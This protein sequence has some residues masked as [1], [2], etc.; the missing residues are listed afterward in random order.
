[1]YV[2]R[3][4]VPIL[5]SALI[6]SKTLFQLLD[7]IIPETLGASTFKADLMKANSIWDTDQTAVCLTYKSKL[8]NMDRSRGFSNSERIC[9]LVLATSLSTSA[10]Y[11]F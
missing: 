7:S 3:C 10:L 1:M 9:S 8:S 11:S 2:Y 6:T 4:L 5:S